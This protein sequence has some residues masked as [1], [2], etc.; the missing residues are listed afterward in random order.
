LLGFGAKARF[1][2][3][4]AVPTPI[5][6]Q[7]PCHPWTRDFWGFWPTFCRFLSCQ[8]RG[9]ARN[10]TSDDEKRHPTSPVQRGRL[11]A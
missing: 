7:V 10:V 6:D 2:E 5:H 11:P 4:D 1:Q 8:R 9:H 3:H